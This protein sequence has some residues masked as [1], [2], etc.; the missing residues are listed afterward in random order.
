M[1]WSNITATIFKE[2]R[3]IF[4][5]KKALKTVLYLPFI[6]PLFIILFGFMFDMMEKTSYN[7]GVNY[8]LSSEEKE[9]IESIGDLNFSKYKNEKELKKA[10]DNKEISSYIIKTNNTYTIYVDTSNNSGSM[11][12]MYLN[13]YLETYNNVLSNKKLIDK[14]IDPYLIYNNIIVNNENLGKEGVDPMVTIILSL[15]VTYIL[16]IVIL[17][18]GVIA[19]DAT[20]G[21]KE[22]GTLETILTFPIKSLELITGKYLAVSIFGIIFGIVSLLFAIPTLYISK[23]LFESFKDISVNI[24]PI[25]MIVL[26]VI[27]I[28]SSLLIAGVCM[29]LAGKS[30]SFKEAQSSLQAI[31]FIPMIPYFLQLLEIDTPIFSLIPIA[32]CG[33]ALNDII[34]NNINVESLLIIIISTIVYTALIILFVS[35]QYKSEKTLFM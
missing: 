1:K 4:R 19:T 31:S 5:D 35:K 20:A 7:V 21:E 17:S 24:E 16:M 13:N 9:I 11:I 10:Y 30:K 33:I 23:S 12:S 27:I 34:L 28:V 26:V 18:C 15:I 2:L 6:I 14:N 22:R 29:A 32:N 25:S 3:G 8:E